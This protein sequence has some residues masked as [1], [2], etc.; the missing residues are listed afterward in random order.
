MHSIEPTTDEAD[1]RMSGTLSFWLEAS[2]QLAAGKFTRAPSAR[3]G[4]GRRRCGRS[5]QSQ[6]HSCMLVIQV[7]DE[8]LVPPW[9]LTVEVRDIDD[10]I[11]VDG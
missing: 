6:P 10:E 3:I 8:Q 7:D 5:S 11:V 9:C 2:I 1:S 4:E